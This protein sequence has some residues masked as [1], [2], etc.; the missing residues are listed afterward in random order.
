MGDFNPLQSMAASAN[1]GISNS[2][3]SLG[4]QIMYQLDN[5]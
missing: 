1:K 4:P 3:A 2:T 5:M